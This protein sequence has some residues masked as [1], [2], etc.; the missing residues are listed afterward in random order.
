MSKGTH[1]IGQPIFLQLINLINRQEISKIERKHSTNR[2]IKRFDGYNHLVTLL[3]SAISGCDSLREVS[4]GM[5]SYSEKLHHLGLDY[6]IKRTTLSDANKRRKSVF[7]ADI[8]D[9]LCDRYGEFISDSRTTNG[10]K[11]KLH[12]IDSTTITLFK[13]ILKGAGRNPKQGKKKGGMKVHTLISS[14]EGLPRL[15]IMTSAATHDH[16]MLKSLD[17][18]EYS[19]IVFDRAYVD[20]AQ[21]ERYTKNK[22]TYV[23]KLKKNAKYEPIEEFDIDDETDDRVLK[24]EVISVKYGAK[25]A[26]E[27]HTRRIAFYNEKT[28]KTIIYLT[29]N[30]ELTAED[31]IEMYKRRW[32]IESLFKQL[33]QN[34]PLKYFLGDNINA[35]ESQIWVTMI[36]NLLL[37]VVRSG[38]KRT[39]S[40]S[41]L[42]SVIRLQLMCYISLMEMLENPEK[43][44]LNLIK[45]RKKERELS[46]F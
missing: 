18:P 27:H 9:M 35:I 21:Y 4:I 22:I 16:I 3:F 24:D 43:S 8:Y 17:L 42:V 46:L 37:T 45:L 36:A 33:K 44:W 28:N 32:Q 7:F 5:A 11:Q 6:V 25:S 30:F 1:F 38:L 12:I 19:F 2:H 14:D 39:W 26:L 23:T 15:N 40:F 34:F 20:Y 13:E 10:K 41:G 29:N 31:I